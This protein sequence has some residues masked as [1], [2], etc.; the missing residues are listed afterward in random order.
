MRFPLALVP[1]FDYAVA[2][3]GNPSN[4]ASFVSRFASF[5]ES[6]ATTAGVPAETGAYAFGFTVFSTL[7]GGSGARPLLRFDDLVYS[8][9]V[10]TARAAAVRRP[11]LRKR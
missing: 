5:V 7:D 6:Q 2:T 9:E 3:D 8:R 10:T 1:Q 4:P 11:L